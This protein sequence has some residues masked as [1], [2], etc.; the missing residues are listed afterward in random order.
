MTCVDSFSWRVLTR[1]S[2][3]TKL[4]FISRTGNASLFIAEVQYF[5]RAINGAGSVVRLAVCK[6]HPTRFGL[7]NV[8][9]TQDIITATLSTS[10]GVGPEI[11][12]VDISALDTKLV[13]AKDGNKLFGIVYHNTSGMA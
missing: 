5:L 10:Q 11:A 6:L 4:C 3:S 12:A 13:T 9:T 1:V 2:F 7:P 8:R